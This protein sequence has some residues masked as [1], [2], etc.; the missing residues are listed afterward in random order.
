MHTLHKMFFLDILLLVSWE[1]LDTC[2]SSGLKDYL[3]ETTQHAT[4][5][6]LIKKYWRATWQQVDRFDRDKGQNMLGNAGFSK[7]NT[8]SVTLD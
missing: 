4:Q 7:N 1:K 2:P 6:Y 5:K 3:T 8:S